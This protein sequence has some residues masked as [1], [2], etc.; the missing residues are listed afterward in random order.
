MTRCLN[1]HCPPNAH[2]ARVRKVEGAIVAVAMLCPVGFATSWEQAREPRV[3][4]RE[5]EAS[6][7]QAA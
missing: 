1:C 3:P 2:R 4:L 5:A 7:E 6:E